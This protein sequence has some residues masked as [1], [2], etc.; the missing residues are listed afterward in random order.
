M[1]CS[2]LYL[3]L[4]V[5]SPDD[6]LLFVESRLGHRYHC[7]SL[8]RKNFWFFDVIVDLV[9]ID[10][11]SKIKTQQISLHTCPGSLACILRRKFFRKIKLAMLER[12]VSVGF[13][14]SARPGS[15]ILNLLPGFIQKN[16]V[17][18]QRRPPVQNS[19]GLELKHMLLEI[20]LEEMGKVG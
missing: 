3:L 1:Q 6:P 14:G 12:S 11:V 13:Q 17:V 5:G 8:L 15:W 10:L 4:I 19:Y 2:I 16:L 9:A 18:K 7:W 20:R